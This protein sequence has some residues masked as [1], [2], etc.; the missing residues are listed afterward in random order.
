VGGLS[1][2]WGKCLDGFYYSLLKGGSQVGDFLILQTLQGGEVGAIDQPSLT[3]VFMGTGQ[4][5]SAYRLGGTA[6]SKYRREK[7]AKGK[8]HIFIL[9]GFP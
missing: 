4:K 9:E 1:S 6:S 7:E 3:G 8:G 5:E 2:G